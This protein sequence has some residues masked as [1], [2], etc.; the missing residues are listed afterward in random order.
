MST[1]MI[2]HLSMHW[3]HAVSVQTDSWRMAGVRVEGGVMVASS[4]T[5]PDSYFVPDC[6]KLHTGPCLGTKQWT[7]L[8][9]H[10]HCTGTALYCTALHYVLTV[11]SIRSGIYWTID[12][13]S[14]C[15]VILCP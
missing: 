14:I 10:W 8:A 6:L 3:G 13:V 11:A 2:H 9:L 1:D 5:A 4:I 15:S 7:A 12:G